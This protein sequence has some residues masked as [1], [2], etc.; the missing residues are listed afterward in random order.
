[1]MGATTLLVQ[2]S[3]DIISRSKTT[4]NED[5][6]EGKKKKEKPI[7]GA[8]TQQ[9]GAADARWFEIDAGGIGNTKKQKPG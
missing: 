7:Q 9:T 8:E 3:T 4:T 1:M 2:R 5:S 6:R